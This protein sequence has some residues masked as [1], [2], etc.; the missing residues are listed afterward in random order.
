MPLIQVSIGTG[1]D[2]DQLRTLV[3]EL[4][5]ATVRAIGARREAVTVVVTQVEATHWANGGTTLADKKVAR[6]AA[7][8]AAA[9]DREGES[10]DA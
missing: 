6:E 1:R 4:T 3:T 8:A 10:D 2:E 5:D 7:A 9:A